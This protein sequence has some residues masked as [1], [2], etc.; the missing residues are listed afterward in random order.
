MGNNSK[1]PKNILNSEQLEYIFYWDSSVKNW[2]E[3]N[4]EKFKE[5]DTSI[6]VFLN[7]KYKEFLN[8]SQAVVNLIPP[9]QNYQVDFESFLQKKIENPLSVRLIKIEK[10]KPKIENQNISLSGNQ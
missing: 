9:L 3:T 4:S 8:G 10:M 1:K 6:Q 7:A 5:Y 2:Y